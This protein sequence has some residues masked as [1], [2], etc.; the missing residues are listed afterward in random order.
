MHHIYVKKD[1][2]MKILHIARIRN[3]KTSGVNVVVPEHIISQSKFEDVYFYNL[4][5][6]KIDG[7]ENNQL[8]FKKNNSL[9]DEIKKEIGNIDIAIIHE[10]NNIDNISIYRQLRKMKIPYIIVPHGELTKKALSKKW[11]KKKIAY[12]FFFNRIIKHSQAIQCLSQNELLNIKYKTYKFV[13]TNGIFDSVIKKSNFST[14]SVNIL[15]LGR[16]EM[17]IKGLDRLLAAINI[18]KEFC[19][20]N[21]VKINI[22]GPDKDGRK[23]ELQKII[24][25]YNI[26][27]ICVINEPVLGKDKEKVILDSDLFIQT[28]RSEGMPIGILEV[29]NYGI[30]CILTKGTNLSDEVKNACAGYA[31]GE[32][33]NEIALSIVQAIEDRNN[34]SKKSVAGIEFTRHNYLWEK[35]SFENIVKYK[36]LL[37]NK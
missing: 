30:P 15:Y 3:A 10:I 31:A 36:E 6:E 32:S 23:K 37:H 14:T 29:L 21:K 2:F 34:W 17:E 12:L 7:L 24:D 18:N 33:D 1:N 19:R 13:G 28:S 8:Y 4:E 20:H 35:V 16:L 25:F 9:L 22:Y 26:N 11:L 5:E 27:D